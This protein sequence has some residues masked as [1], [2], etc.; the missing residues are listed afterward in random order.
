MHHEC[1]VKR[2]SCILLVPLSSP[3][4]FIIIARYIH[5]LYFWT[6]K[7]LCLIKE[8]NWKK[9]QTQ[10]AKTFMPVRLK[11]ILKQY[12]FEIRKVFRG[13]RACVFI[14]YLFIC[15]FFIYFSGP[16]SSVG[17]ATDY[18]LDGPGSNPGGGEIFHPS[19]LALRPTQPPVKWVPGLSQV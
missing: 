16:G 9:L 10:F 7:Y 4:V 11:R 2:E 14:I 15:I 13:W 1:R 12:K 8:E 18:G 19:R 6:Y 3:S 17:I 5:P